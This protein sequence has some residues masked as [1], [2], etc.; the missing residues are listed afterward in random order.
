MLPV[1]SYDDAPHGH[2]EMTFDSVRVPLG[3][4]VLGEGRGF[5][6]AQGRLGPGTVQWVTGQYST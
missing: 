5:E 1:Y 2:V 6:I 4:M 3:N